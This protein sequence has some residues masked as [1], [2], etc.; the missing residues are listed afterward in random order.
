MVEF[1]RGK[2][3]ELAA[4]VLEAQAAIEELHG[5]IVAGTDD[6]NADAQARELYIKA[7]WYKTFADGVAPTPGVKAA[8]NFEGLMNYYQQA[9]AFADEGIALYK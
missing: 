6:A 5:L 3:A 4:V 8:M 1:V 9:K 2:Q 7:Y